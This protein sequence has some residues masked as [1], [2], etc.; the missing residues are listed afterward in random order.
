MNIDELL[1]QIEDV[2]ESGKN[3]PLTNKALVDVGSIKTSI[4]DI[5]MNLPNEISQAKAI[6]ADEQ[7]IKAKAKNEA[8]S[9]VTQARETAQRTQEDTESKI[10]VLIAKAE[11]IA[12]KKVFAAN[13]EADA[14][15]SA[16]QIRSNQLVDSH[17]ITLAAKDSAAAIK[18]QT[19]EEA[20]AILEKAKEQA[21]QLLHSA[22]NK[23]E[24][25]ILSTKERADKLMVEAEKWSAELRT[26]AGNY[27][28]RI[29]REANDSLTACANKVNE[30]KQKIS[31]AMQ[32]VGN[33]TKSD[34]SR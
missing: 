2:L 30:S 8:V 18:K 21:E 34:K 10:S 1:D 19:Q 14:T 9:I 24:Q 7:N 28:E 11:E 5:R 6:A 22:K 17:S 3:M 4:E 33:I 23:K 12:K 32:K 15:L 27:A 29:M 16:A 13:E 31:E 20:D 25:E 26:S